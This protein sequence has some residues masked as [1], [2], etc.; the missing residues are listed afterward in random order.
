M[1]SLVRRKC[2]RAGRR[3]FQALDF[4]ELVS[5]DVNISRTKHEWLRPD[6]VAFNREQR[7][8]VVFEFK[9]SIQTERQ[10][11]TEL[12]AYEH[13]IRNHLPFLADYDIVYVL[14]ATDF[15][16]LLEHAAAGAITWS[17][18]HVLC[19][20]AGVVANELCLRVHIPRAWEFLG[21][22]RFPDDSLPTMTIGIAASPDADPHGVAAQ[23]ASA[24]SYA[25]QL[26]ERIGSHGFAILF[27]DDHERSMYSH[28]IT[29][30]VVDP[31]PFYYASQNE[32]SRDTGRSLAAFL[33]RRRAELRAGND[34][35]S[36]GYIA[37]ELMRYLKPIGE[38]GI[39]YFVDYAVFRTTQVSSCVPLRVESWGLIGDKCR[40]QVLHP[41]AAH[42][43]HGDR[44]GRMR[45]WRSPFVS[46]PILDNL[47]NRKLFPAG[48]IRPS[49]ALRL[50]AIIGMSTELRELYPHVEGSQ[51]IT[52]ECLAAWNDIDFIFAQHEIDFVA[53]AATNVK[54]ME[55]VLPVPLHVSI[56][57]DKD[58][59]T[60]FV[61][62]LHDELLQA[63]A[64]QGKW[65]GLGL[66]YW[67]II[68]DSLRNS[69]Y[70]ATKDVQ[71][72]AEHVRA[73]L[74][75]AVAA[76][77]EMTA[78]RRGP[79]SR[80]YLRAAL[81]ALGLRGRYTTSK[82][83]QIAASATAEGIVQA[84]RAIVEAHDRMFEPVFL[85]GGPFPPIVV[86]WE[87]L[88]SRAAQQ[89]QRGIVRPSLIRLPDGN[90]DIGPY[91]FPFFIKDAIPP[92]EITFCDLT[93][94]APIARIVTWAD[95]KRGKYFAVKTIGDMRTDSG[96]E[97]Q[98]PE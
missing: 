51:R 10:A 93:G 24:L 50:G 81:A 80:R 49:D 19:L 92:Q 97:P 86:D 70:V 6:L 39:E 36:A 87:E 84:T 71:D 61:Q 90:L 5:V 32:G 2:A 65:F 66:L 29:I 34:F 12:L 77:S 20:Q 31:F 94:I 78:G 96:N 68:D 69:I 79:L 26:G 57:W 23:L 14:C 83:R 59:V 30:G 82:A 64:P 74:L 85:I 58:A 73:L 4:L 60:K 41:G 1:E 67:S 88:Q 42:A 7:T 18:K 13:E 44:S 17:G 62:W 98:S 15:S 38:I 76:D 75:S 8:V 25:A 22:S 21:A 55:G 3:V 47:V 28:G 52:I 95:L 48:K 56:P 89:N 33:D 40:E 46:V 9:R 53:G 35:A 63:Q 16:A 37:S 72:F 11:L 27:K 91:P 54:R 45:D 43:L